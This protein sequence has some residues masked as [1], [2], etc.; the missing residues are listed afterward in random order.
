MALA[1]VPATCEGNTVSPARPLHAA[2]SHPQDGC[3]RGPPWNS[4][5]W[6]GVGCRREDPDPAKQGHLLLPKSQRPPKMLLFLHNH[7]NCPCAPELGLTAGRQPSS[8]ALSCRQDA[9]THGPELSLPCRHRGTGSPSLPHVFPTP[10][11]R[12]LTNSSAAAPPFGWLL[13]LAGY[14]VE[15][16]TAEDKVVLC[17]FSRWETPRPYTRTL[18]APEAELTATRCHTDTRSRG[19][20]APALQ[21]LRESVQPAEEPHRQTRALDGHTAR[22]QNLIPHLVFPSSLCVSC[23]FSSFIHFPV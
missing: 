6:S 23:Y 17:G 10:G 8:R 12:R 19:L 9:H 21:Q 7:R 16:L 18:A 22:T 2:N 5:T 3:L 11:G 14:C 15:R 1:L 20:P 4:Q 13:W